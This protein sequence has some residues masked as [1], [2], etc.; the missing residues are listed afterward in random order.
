VF[1]KKAA[2]ATKR[3]WPELQNAQNKKKKKKKKKKEE[4]FG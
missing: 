3:K 4:K 1:T 2:K